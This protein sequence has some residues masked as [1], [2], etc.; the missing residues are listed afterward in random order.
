MTNRPESEQESKR[1]S[2]EK[3]PRR[4]RA[5]RFLISWVYFP[6]ALFI[7]SVWAV[8]EA[9]YWEPRAVVL[10]YW[11]VGGAALILALL[12]GVVILPVIGKRADRKNV[13][14]REALSF[15]A[16]NLNYEDG[17]EGLLHGDSQGNIVDGK[18]PTIWNDHGETARR[19]LKR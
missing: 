9:A 13:E 5:A 3:A 11:I 6:A 2:G 18:P 14:L 19:A 10:A 16:E 1:H 8:G 15:Y 12:I 17:H 4:D 7:G